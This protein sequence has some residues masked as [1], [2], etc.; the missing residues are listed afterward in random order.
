MTCN[1]H[2]NIEISDLDRPMAPPAIAALAATMTLQECGDFQLTAA[3]H[4]PQLQDFFQNFLQSATSLES[5]ERFYVTTNP[6]VTA[7]AFSLF[8]APVFLVASEIN[9]NYSQ[10]DRCWSILPSVYTIHYA[11]WTHA[12]GLPCSRVDLLLGV[13]LTWS[14]SGTR[15]MIGIYLHRRRHASRST[16]GGR[17]ATRSGLKIIAGRFSKTTSAPLSSSSSMSRSSLSPKAYDF[18]SQ[19]RP[20][21][22]SN[23]E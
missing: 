8:L 18:H 16:T 1:R 15:N 7:F 14:V 12:A 22:Q 20:R 10:V 21:V 17:G 23:M 13:T 5:I 9:K 2:L 11:L 19:P 6:L 4:L 3:R